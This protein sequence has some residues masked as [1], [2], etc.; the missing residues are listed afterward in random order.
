MAMTPGTR[1]L[2]LSAARYAVGISSRGLS[3]GTT[4]GKG[5]WLA[6]SS[7]YARLMRLD[8][9]I[10]STLLFLPAAWAIVM[11]SPSL[12]EA[13][14]T[15][16]LFASGSVLLRGAG[17]TIN[18]YWDRDIDKQVKRTATRPIAAG[19]VSPRNALL[20]FSAQCLAGLPI[21]LSMNATTIYLGV[22]SLVP[23]I[24]LGVCFNF[25]ALM[26][27]TAVT[28]QL[29]LPAVLLYLGC[30]CWTQV[31]DTIYAHADKADDIS[32]NIGSS[33]LVLKDGTKKALTGFSLMSYGLVGMAGISTGLP[34]LFFVFLAP[35]QIDLLNRIQR[36][37][38]DNPES[39]IA[40][41][42]AS[43][44]TGF[45]VLLAIIIAKQI[46]QRE[47]K[48]EAEEKEAEEAEETMEQDS[49]RIGSW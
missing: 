11:A 4:G 44:N 5:G 41:F 6:R 43:R 32:V 33:A 49:N 29:E 24:A 28:N 12:T 48:A 38:L 7:P 10:G 8:K 19:E 9:P 47:A 39:C 26:G 16:A 14:P 22:F 1:M 40:S 42:Q 45:L 27:W 23:V 17:C 21:L 3:S 25:G 35:S 13:V 18:D 46:L 34:P 37:D 20:F 2:G 15:L 31:Y 36:T 30:F